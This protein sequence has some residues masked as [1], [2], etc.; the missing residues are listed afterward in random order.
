MWPVLVHDF[1]VQLFLGTL[2]P[3]DLWKSALPMKRGNKKYRNSATASMFK[4]TEGQGQV[5]A[6]FF[7]AVLT[8]LSNAQENSWSN[9]SVEN[10]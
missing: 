7:G 6:T 9:M 1:C 3:E 2:P 4:G 10:S 5:N 8:W